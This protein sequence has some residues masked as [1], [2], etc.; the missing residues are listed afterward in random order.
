LILPAAA[1]ARDWVAKVGRAADGQSGKMGDDPS[2]RWSGPRRGGH[3]LT[4]GCATC[5]PTSCRRVG[6]QSRR[7]PNRVARIV[8]AR[9]W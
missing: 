7:R 5:W 1:H 6:G 4:P 8:V 2:R 3:N 9:R